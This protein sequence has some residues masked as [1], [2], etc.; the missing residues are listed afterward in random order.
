MKLFIS[1]ALVLLLT[2]CDKSYR[3]VNT[4]YV[5][6]EELSDCKIYKLHDGNILN[7]VIVITRCPNSST[8]TNHQ[9]GKV[10]VNNI[11]VDGVEYKKAE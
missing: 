8:S 3:D 6:P 11:V 2:G 7:G 9:V 1:V 5:L 10:R 4:D